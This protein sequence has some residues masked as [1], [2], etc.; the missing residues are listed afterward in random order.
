M[1]LSTRAKELS[2]LLSVPCVV[3]QYLVIFDVESV[4]AIR[5]WGD[6][7]VLPVGLRWVQALSCRL[8]SRFLK[9]L[10]GEVAG[11]VDLAGR[12]RW[13]RGYQVMTL[14]GV[15]HHISL[16]AVSYLSKFVALWRTLGCPEDSSS[17]NVIL[18]HI[19]LRPSSPLELPCATQPTA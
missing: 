17:S 6:K 19:S 15:A 10:G 1:G 8:V 3:S 9:R 18:H 12:W 11:C 4:L 14:F 2:A 5:L 7:V 13:A 16:F